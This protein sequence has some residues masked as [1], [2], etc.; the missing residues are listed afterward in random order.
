MLSLQLHLVSI[1]YE[2]GKNLLKIVSNII[3]PSM[4][5]NMHYELIKALS[6]DAFRVRF[7]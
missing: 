5:Y 2:N 7:N 3:F 6:G 1:R 4:Y